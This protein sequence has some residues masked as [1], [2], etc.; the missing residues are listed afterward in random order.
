MSTQAKVA[1]EPKRGRKGVFPATTAEGLGKPQLGWSLLGA[2]GGAALLFAGQVAIEEYRGYRAG[3]AKAADQQRALAERRAQQAKQAFEAYLA[4]DDLPE[5]AG[6]FIETGSEGSK[7]DVAVV[8]RHLRMIIAYVWSGELTAESIASLYGG[9]LTYW[10]KQFEALGSGRSPVSSNYLASQ[11]QNFLVLAGA[12]DT[13]A[14]PKSAKPPEIVAPYVIEAP[15]PGP[16][17][18]PNAIDEPSVTDLT[19][20]PN[21]MVIPKQIRPPSKAA[22]VDAT[23]ADGAAKL[24]KSSPTNQA[25]PLAPLAAAH[26]EE[27]AEV[28]IVND[29]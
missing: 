13:L 14:D 11:R 12:L 4:L 20:P 27:A 6:A 8:T 26:E 29:D 3:A 16:I 24:A 5:R 9:R 25:A 10:S 22:I 21:A 19:L 7:A 28:E 18:P 2:V 17:M 1:T 15:S 23:R